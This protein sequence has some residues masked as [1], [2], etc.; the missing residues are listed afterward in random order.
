MLAIVL[1]FVLLTPGI[2]L[3]IS[4]GFGKLGAAVIHG[5]VF[6]MVLAY[7][8]DIPLVREVL[9]LADSVY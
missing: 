3:N 5:V 8:R 2:L 7:R 1:L 6:A 4:F 9:N